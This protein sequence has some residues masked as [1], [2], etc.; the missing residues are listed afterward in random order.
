MKTYLYDGAVIYFPG[1]EEYGIDPTFGLVDLFYIKSSGDLK[2]LDYDDFRKS[3]ISDM[4]MVFWDDGIP[5]FEFRILNDDAYHLV[6]PDT[7]QNRLAI[8]LKYAK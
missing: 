2:A 5:T 8:Q 7:P 3:E 6:E 1:D 4:I